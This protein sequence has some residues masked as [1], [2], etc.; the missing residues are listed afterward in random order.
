MYRGNKRSKASI[1]IIV[2]FNTKLGNEGNIWDIDCYINSFHQNLDNEGVPE[3][4]IMCLTFSA[5]L[6]TDFIYQITGRKI[7]SQKYGCPTVCN[8]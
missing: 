1:K 8:N 3:S 4:R 2:K 5:I 7:S 6:R